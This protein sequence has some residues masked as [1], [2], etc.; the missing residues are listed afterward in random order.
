LLHKIDAFR[1]RGAIAPMEDESFVPDSWRA[2]FLGSGIM[3]E[4]WPPATDRVPVSRMQDEVRR[5]LSAIK[6]KVLEQP[7]HDAYL[8]QLC[9]RRAA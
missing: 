9:R 7:R 4:S 6:A 2:Q 8:A 1:A 3:P 5:M